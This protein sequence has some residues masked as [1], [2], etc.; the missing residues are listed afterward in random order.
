[1][2][3]PDMVLIGGHLFAHVRQILPSSPLADLDLNDITV[4]DTHC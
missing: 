3:T 4:L 2:H 1:M